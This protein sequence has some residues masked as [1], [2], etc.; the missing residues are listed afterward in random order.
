M[1]EFRPV[2]PRHARN[3]DHGMRAALC[4]I[5]RHL[6]CLAGLVAAELGL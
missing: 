6:Q 1:R 2:S 3:R 5:G 4:T